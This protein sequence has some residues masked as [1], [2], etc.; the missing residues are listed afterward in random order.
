MPA[1]V[2]DKLLGRFN[3]QAE[4]GETAD[5]QKGV[6]KHLVVI[7]NGQRVDLDVEGHSDRVK[8]L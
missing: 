1:K 3:M 5:K 8:V 4:F 7:S 6:D 2:L